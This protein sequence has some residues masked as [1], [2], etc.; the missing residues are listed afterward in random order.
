M[1]RDSA[2]VYFYTKQNCKLCEDVKQL[3]Q[4]LQ[5]DYHFSIVEQNIYQD[6][7]LLEDYFLLIPVV[8][9]GSREL[10]ADSISF[11]TLEQ[12]LQEHLT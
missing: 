12:F 10:S 2:I 5:M 7:R 8:R 9:I 3:L 6:E 4:I 1:A 11:A